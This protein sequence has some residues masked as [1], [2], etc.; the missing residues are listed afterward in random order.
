ML[1][2]FTNCKWSLQ[3]SGFGII[4]CNK[5]Q[6]LEVGSPWPRNDF[7]IHYLIL[8]HICALGLKVEEYHTGKCTSEGLYHIPRSPSSQKYQSKSLCTERWTE[9]HFTVTGKDK[10]C[11]FCKS[12]SFLMSYSLSVLILFNS[13]A[14]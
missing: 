3:P 5:G 2:T 12:V 14:S 11:V 13:L 9:A 1:N 6:H 4:F 10:A 8:F 7:N